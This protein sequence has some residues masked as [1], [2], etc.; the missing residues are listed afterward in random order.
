MPAYTTPA[1]LDD[2][3]ALLAS[4]KGQAMVIAGGTDLIPDLRRGVKCPQALVDIS[5]IPE[6]A[7]IE[8]TGE[9]LVVGAATTFA[10]LKEHLAIRQRV[11]ALAEAASA[12]GAMGIQTAATWG[13]N[14]VQA[15]PAADGA[16]VALALE[17]EARVA[18]PG[19]AA[20]RPVASL[21]RGPGQSVIDPTRQI[22]THI[23]VPLPTSPLDRAQGKRWG[24]AW[25][26]V[27]RRDSLVLPIL[28]C[29]VKLVLENASMPYDPPNLGGQGGVP[30][31]VGQVEV[32]AED[33]IERA[34]IALGPVA[35]RPFRAQEAESFLAGKPLSIEVFEEAGRIA[36]RES[37][38]RSSVMRA[39]REYRLAVIPHIVSDA[40]AAA[41]HRAQV[42]RRIHESLNQ[43]LSGSVNQQSEGD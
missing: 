23:R 10:A 19:G 1:T 21:F 38:P 12:V 5:R 3:L 15:M 17:A 4:H 7:H 2:A 22:L 6:L 28:N 30:N 39:S 35:P 13:G 16:I 42:G 8:M 37:N 34:T 14:L 40:L 32:M 29:A 20:W 31:L 33:L 18:E 11:P 41:A 9:W 43:R 36:Q 24:S 26:R 27:G 25:R